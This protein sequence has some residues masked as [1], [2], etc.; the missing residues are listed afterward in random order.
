MKLDI[1][2]FAAHPDDVELSCSGTLLLHKSLGKKIG[3]VDLTRGEMGTRGTP[4]TRKKEADAASKILQL[5]ARENL[6]FE[7]CFFIN[8][9]EHRMKVVS[10]IRK[11]Q[12]NIVLAN[13]IADRHP[14]HARAAQLISESCFIAGLKKTETIL[15]GNQQSLWKVKALYHYMQD[16]YIKPDFVVDVSEWFEKKMESVLAY[17]SQFYNPDSKETDTPI[18]SKNF[19]EF[20]RSRAAEMGRNIGVQ[21]A[22]GFTA[23]RIPGIKNISDLI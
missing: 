16:R 10:V 21:Y 20:L 22:E 4:E 14:D 15:D 23:S 5:D 12:P 18:S 7:D 13:A 6:G 11:Y 8:D 3:I 9:K 17:K 2:A 1:L 19:L